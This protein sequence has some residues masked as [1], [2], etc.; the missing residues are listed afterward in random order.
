MNLSNTARYAIRI[1]AYMTA[2]DEGLYSASSLV[3]ELNISDKYLKHLMTSM[4]RAGLV[5]STRGR[6]GGFMLTRPADEIYLNEIINA[7]DNHEKY[8]GCILGF[9]ECSDENACALHNEW[10]KIKI[11]IDSLFHHVTLKN[12]VK[13]Q[14]ILKY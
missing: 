10:F 2:K 5:T 13:Q 12:I 7:V 14:V 9:N 3:K 8:N 6:I 11:E 4:G 1:L